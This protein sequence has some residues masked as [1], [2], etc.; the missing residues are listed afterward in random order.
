M[1]MNKIIPRFGIALFVVGLL[2]VPVFGLSD[3]PS[4]LNSDEELTV[5]Y[6]CNCHNNGDSSPRAVVMITGVPIM[7]ELS[8]TYNLT[9][10]VADSL[11]LSGGD[12]NVKAG[13]LLSSDA[14][15]VFSWSDDQDIMQ[16]KERPD[17][18]SH[19]ETDSDGV[20]DF[21]WT[22]PSENVGQ[23][24]FWL[25]GNSVDGGGIPDENDYWNL[26]SFSINEPGTIT[27]TESDSTLQTRTIS[28]GDYD[29][30]F[31]LEV[32]DE[33]LEKERQD[34]LSHKLFKQGNLFFWT[35]LVA[36]I[37]GG[38]FQREILERR[39]GEGP[40]YLAR[41]LAVPQAIRRSIGCII[42]FYM[43]FRWTVNDAIIQFPP[44]SIVGPDAE[45]TDLTVFIIGCFYFISAWFAYGVYRT[46]LAANSEPKV[47]DIL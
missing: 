10:T 2:I 6:G 28:V 44:P 42:S 39:F 8:E 13:F 26:V 5:K 45:V 32:T 36:L 38:V 20:W 30:L 40:E 43:A 23:V 11:T 35:S 15:G 12:G 7:Y 18:I 3:G 14:V 25:A 34:K 9:V 37:V 24:N 16:A 17:D 22:A 31:V 19:S 4:A 33:Q 46:I 41:E 29:S 27:T 1:P 47:K 21:R